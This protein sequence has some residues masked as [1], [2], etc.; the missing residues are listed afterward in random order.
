VGEA[1]PALAGLP[2]PGDPVFYP[3]VGHCIYRGVTKDR[4][5]PGTRLLELED[6]EEDSR[7]LI[8]LARIPELNLRP[9]G[10]ALEDIKE[11]L[12][13]EFEEPIESKD[14]R[15]DLVEKLISDGSPRALAQA[16]KRLHLIRQTSDLSREEELTRKK[17]RSWLAAEVAI[18]KECT[19]AE[20]QAFMTRVLQDS[21]AAHRLKEKEEAKE[22]RR[23]A[24]KQKRAAQELARAESEESVESVEP[25]ESV[26][27]G[28][29]VDSTSPYGVASL[30]E[31]KHPVGEDRE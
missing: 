25:M 14:E 29:S 3:K 16:L 6:L 8:P 12:S 7:I 17:V 18:S 10:L 21:M 2:K 4:M 19:R 28:E 5:A 9:A 30:T 1:N 11:T 22:R 23:A 31:A 15:H 27:P 24:K 26:E 20:A 13:A